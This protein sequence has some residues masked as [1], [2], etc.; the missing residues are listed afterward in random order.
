[1]TT[2][3]YELRSTADGRGEGVFAT[4]DF[5]PGETVMVAVIE[6]RLEK[7]HSHATQIDEF[8]YVELAGLAPKVNHSC[9]PN[10]G[11]RLNSSGAPDLIAR[12]LIRRGD[13]VTF[14]YAM[15]NYTVDCFPS[16][17]RCG[18][19]VCRG[20]VTGWKDLPDET[21]RAYHGLVAPY[22]LALNTRAATA[23]LTDAA[24]DDNDPP[25]RPEP[26]PERAL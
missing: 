15:R 10:C 19:G 16:V 21:K 6:R 24:A 12:R 22:L 25:A 7:N 2:G 23:D 13:E 26:V 20:S 18:S 17:C 9:D 8:Q 5:R 1:M 14:D 11:V 3:G 4:R